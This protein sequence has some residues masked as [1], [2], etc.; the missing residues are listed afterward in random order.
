ML[1]PGNY[2]CLFDCVF[3]HSLLFVSYGYFVHFVSLQVFDS[4]LLSVSGFCRYYVFRRLALGEATSPAEF[5]AKL[6]AGNSPRGDQ[7]RSPTDSAAVP[8][9]RKRRRDS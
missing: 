4:M 3:D 8:S 5:L 6:H 1:T 7:P 2:A 9:R